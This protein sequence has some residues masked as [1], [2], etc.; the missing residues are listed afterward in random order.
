MS[1][2][3]VATPSLVDVGVSAGSAVGVGSFDWICC[4]EFLLFLLLQ[5]LLELLLEI[6][7]KLLLELLLVTVQCF[8]MGSELD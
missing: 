1:V 6:K 8:A 5:F 7:I 4:W 2:V 3:G